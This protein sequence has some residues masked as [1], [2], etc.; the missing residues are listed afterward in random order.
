MPDC[1]ILS[2][3]P[4][5]QE[6]SR[7][8][9]PELS[10]Y[11]LDGLEPATPYRVWLSV[12]WPSGEGSPTEVTAYTSEPRGLTLPWSALLLLMTHPEILHPMTLSDSSYNP[13]HS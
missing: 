7:D 1:S 8:L 11:E 5:G 10:S 12:L 13:H 2:P 4:G 3:A 6:Q 9:G